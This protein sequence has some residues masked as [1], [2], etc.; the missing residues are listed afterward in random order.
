MAA[1]SCDIQKAELRYQSEGGG[2]QKN[3]GCSF[4]G[5]QLFP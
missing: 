1:F 4:K 5:L 3:R 2:G